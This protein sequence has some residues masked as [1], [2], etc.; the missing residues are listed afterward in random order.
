M[1]IATIKKNDKTRPTHVTSSSLQTIIDQGYEIVSIKYDPITPRQLRL[2]LLQIGITPD[3]VTAA[4]DQMD[5]PTK[6][7]AQIEWEYA[8]EVKRD[9]PLIDQLAAAFDK[10]AEDVDALFLAA[11]EI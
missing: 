3:M 6:T 2:A 11:S 9:H 1:A 8:L 7:A 10:T 5:E 4:I